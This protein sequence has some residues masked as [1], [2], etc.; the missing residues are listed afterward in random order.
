MV[1]TVPL[2]ASQLNDG[3]TAEDIKKVYAAKYVGEL[4]KYS[5]SID[6][7]GMISAAGMSLSD[8]MQVTVAGNDDRILLI[9]RYDNLGKGASGAAVQCLNLIT[10]ANK[11]DGLEI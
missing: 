4:V 3:K 5:P 11:T 8:A 7:N 1:V 10:G 9:A 2:F 6:E